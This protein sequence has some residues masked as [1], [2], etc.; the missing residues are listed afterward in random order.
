MIEVVVAGHLCLDIIPQFISDAGSDMGAYVA[1]GRLT[2]VGAVALSTGG[3]V[4]NTGINLHHLGVETRLMGKIGNDLFGRAILEIINSYHAKLA[5]GMVIV[6]DE[7]TASTIVI[8]PPGV[9][10]AF[11][12]C[13]GA[14]RTFGAEDI[15]YDLLQECKLFHF[16]YPPLMRRMYIEGGAELAK[17][18]QRAKAT[19]VTTSL[20][21]AMP[22]RSSA[23]RNNPPISRW[24]WTRRSRP[25]PAR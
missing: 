16:G 18:Y 21:L 6:P 11:L 23:S 24:A 5:E 13:P 17:M 14:N 12:H 7:I 4:S 20:D 1:P 8:N 19:G 22:D 15:R 2:D 25:K 10:R 9:D 3:A